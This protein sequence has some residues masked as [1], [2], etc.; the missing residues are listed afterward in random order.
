MINKDTSAFL[1][2]L[3][4]LGIVSLLLSLTQGTGSMFYAGFVVWLTASYLFLSITG[5]TSEMRRQIQIR[6]KKRH[7][8]DAMQMH[9]AAM[10]GSLTT[11]C[12]MLLLYTLA[13]QMV[14]SHLF[15]IRDAYLVLYTTAPAV[16][17]GSFI[18]D[19]R[20]LLEAVNSKH[21]SRLSM[22]LLGVLTVV[23]S[24]ICS[25]SMA[26]RGEKV[27]ALL[28]NTGYKAVYVAAGAGMGISA[29]VII[30]VMVLFV[31][32]R[33][34]VHY[35]RDHEDHLAIDNDEQLRE[36]YLYYFFKVGPYAVIGLL[37][38]LMLIIDYR[39]YTGTLSGATAADYH[40]EWGGFIGITVPVMLLWIC[41]CAALFS[42]EIDRLVSEYSK[43]AYKQLRLRFSMVMRLSGYVLIPAVFFTFGAAKPFVTIFHGGLYGGAADGAIL[44]LKYLSPLAFLGT[45][46]LILGIF[47]WKSEYQSLV[48]VSILFGTAFEIG[49]MSILIG[50][51]LGMY[52]VPIAMDIFAAAFLAS[53]YYLG[54]R[55]IL[56]R[57]DTRWVV[58]DIMVTFSAVIAAV[59]VILLNDVMTEQIYPLIGVILLLILYVVLYVILAICLGCTDYG[60]IRRFPGGRYIVQLAIIL[61]K[62]AEE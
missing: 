7:F 4:A 21:V 3:C 23:L 1:V 39:F 45:T 51:G 18:G 15:G 19:L 26:V 28:M 43:K 50:A 24:T 11:G 52:A 25:V 30:T 6:I 10:L 55:Q 34:A 14:S 9:R 13:A 27:G 49:A 56:A 37:P 20:G 22:L 58:D 59:P 53:A 36:L 40:S 46:A 17:L 48:I 2:I 35:I 57:C 16:F 60:N 12:I 5:G 38:V 8:N 54:R 31:M 47:Y 62:A 33:F 41:I 29:A 42:R 32:S 61:G 44:S